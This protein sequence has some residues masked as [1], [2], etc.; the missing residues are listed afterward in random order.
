[1]KI[2][3]KLIAG[4]VG[5]AL[6]GGAI[7]VLGITNTNKIAEADRSMYTTMTQP[8]GALIPMA[9]SIETLRIDIRLYLEAKDEASRQ[10][11]LAGIP[12]E[13]SDI[14]KGGAVFKATI[15]TDKARQLFAEY[16]RALATYYAALDSIEQYGRGGKF[17]D[18]MAYAN[19]PASAAAKA[20]EGAIGS[21]VELKVS[22]SKETADANS[23]LSASAMLMLMIAMAIGLAASLALG[24]A[25]SISMSRPIA[26]IVSFTEAISGGDLTKVVHA[27][28]LNRTDEFGNLAHA[29]QDMQRNLRKVVAELQT[30]VVNI[31]SGSDQVS[32]SA[33]QL[34]QGASE[35]AA[36][37]EE[38][39]ASVEEMNATIKQNADNAISTE[40]I[41][42]QS[43]SRGAEGGQAV[44]ETVAAMK[45]IASST[46]IIEE[47]AR[48]TNL[49]ALNAA[50]EAARAGEAGKGFA[51]VASEVRKLAERSQTAA[52]EIGKLSVSSV[53]VA[54]KAGAMLTEIVPE[55]K[56]TSSLVQEISASSKEQTSGTEQIA[57]A[58]MQLD[59][60]VQDNAS[61]SEELASMSEEL[62]GQA[63]QLAETVGF[64]K[65]DEAGTASEA[66]PAPA[67]GGGLKEHAGGAG[68]AKA[69]RAIDR[70]RAPEKPSSAK[71]PTAITLAPAVA[72]G[73][74]GSATNASDADFEEF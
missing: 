50:I 11:A 27:D 3:G 67:I 7:G 20:L 10:T 19:G 26:R 73:G 60:V 41:A 29:F 17:A 35:Q 58:I 33:Q 15:V 30:A 43:A 37:A 21:L 70:A 25:M 53:A 69:P 55:L 52:G 4:F 36:S 16:E 46:A 44:A 47:I 61:N 23:A 74:T 8:L 34:S 56:K 5:V 2:G 51:V 14:E 68:K 39:S 1:M 45:Q 6:I 71:R 38:V 31:S 18:A 64:F 12:G 59:Q 28:M 63:R 22:L 13:K 65:V 24:I 40:A 49:L 48:Q 62:S 42:N 57:K 66:K 9:E 72:G 32:N 54:E